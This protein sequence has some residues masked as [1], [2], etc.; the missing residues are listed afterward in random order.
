MLKKLQSEGTAGND[1]INYISVLIE[2]G[3]SV[4]SSRLKFL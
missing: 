1:V 3:D 2:F 4:G